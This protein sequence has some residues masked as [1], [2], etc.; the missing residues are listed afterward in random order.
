LNVLVLGYGKIGR[1]KA[2]IWK[3]LGR[4]VYI[5]EPSNAKQ[6]DILI[7]G[8]KV[9]GDTPLEEGWIADIST[10]A[11]Q[12][13]NSLKWILD[14]GQAMPAK[15]LVEKPL[16]SSITEMDELEALIATDDGKSIR[17]RVMLNETY[18]QSAV[19]DKLCRK[20][21]KGD[22]Q[23]LS[24]SIELSKNRLE[25]IGNGRFTDSSLGPVGIE[26][27]HML[28]IL[29]KLGID[30]DFLDNAHGMIISHEENTDNTAFV[31]QYKKDN[32]CIG[33]YSYLGNFRY[34]HTGLLQNND[35]VPRKLRIR[36]TTLTYEIDF[37]PVAGQRRYISRLRVYNTH[38]N[39]FKE[40]LLED[41]HLTRQISEVHK[42]PVEAHAHD[43]WLS[44]DNGMLIS[45]KLLRLR[46]NSMIVSEKN[47]IKH[48]EELAWQ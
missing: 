38:D 4:D 26:V 45:R 9:Y 44:L 23:I 15:I 5:Y 3:S 7:D 6:K 17:G 16:V 46:D 39:T 8:H 19:L 32:F 10:P 34:D 1:I 33:L 36:T 30:L 28:A 20:L 24:I 2:S 37:D 25:D 48:K 35:E 14:S 18:Y 27:P 11:G 12:H 31:L 13:T 21:E 47:F 40:E 43:Q 42:M 41:N 29:Q 22:S